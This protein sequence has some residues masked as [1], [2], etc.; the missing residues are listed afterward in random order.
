M[1]KKAQAKEKS[2]N[3]ISKAKE[4]YGL[5]GRDTGIDTESVPFAESY[6]KS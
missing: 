1:N 3:Q 6:G 5:T 4:R 2:N